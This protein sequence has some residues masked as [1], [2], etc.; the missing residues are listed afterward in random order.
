M[1]YLKITIKTIKIQTNIN[2]I[3]NIRILKLNN[4]IDLKLV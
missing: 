4:N 1:D 3:I 2:K